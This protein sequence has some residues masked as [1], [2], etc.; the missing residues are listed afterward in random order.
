MLIAKVASVRAW[1][2]MN[3]TEGAP[4]LHSRSFVLICGQVFLSGQET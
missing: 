1:M 3:A 2:Q 4:L